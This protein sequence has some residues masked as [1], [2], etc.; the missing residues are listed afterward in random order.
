MGAGRLLGFWRNKPTESADR[1][2]CRKDFLS[3]RR[4]LPGQPIEL[5]WSYRGQTYI[6]EMSDDQ[7][8]SNGQNMLEFGISNLRFKLAVRGGKR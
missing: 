4:S 6:A 5:V 1:W 3:T 8:L 2:L 7:A